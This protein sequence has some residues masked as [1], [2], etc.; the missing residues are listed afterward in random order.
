M[1]VLSLAK[2]IERCVLRAVD[3]EGLRAGWHSPYY[4][5][6]EPAL[7]IRS[8]VRTRLPTRFVTM[9]ELGEA[10]EIIEAD[11]E[12]VLRFG[13]GGQP[14]VAIRL[15][16]PRAGVSPVVSVERDGKA[17]VWES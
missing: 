10:V 12:R 3:E 14:M 17:Y 16:P 7:T 1:R 4:G 8:S 9:V 11:L 6:R 15:E 2:E 5:V 13:G